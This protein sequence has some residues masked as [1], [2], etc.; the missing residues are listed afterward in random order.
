[1]R[2]TWQ[3]SQPAADPPPFVFEDGPN[4][5]LLLLCDHASSRMPAE[6]GDL[7]LHA[8]AALGH[9]VWDPGAEGIARAMSDALACPLFTGSYS[10]L[11]V[12]LNRTPDAADLIVSENDG[13][14]VPGNLLLAAHERQRRIACYH[15]PYH[16][17]IALHLDGLS[18]IGIGPL[19][20][21]IHTYTP[22]FGGRQRPWP[23]GIL[24]K[25]H[26]P[27]LDDVFDGLHRQG[28]AVG[29]NEPYDG[30]IAL[31]HTLEQHALR[32][33]LR[34]ILFEV[35]QDLVDSSRQQAEWAGRLL[36]AL[37]HAGLP[38]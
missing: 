5:R 18:T 34:S 24:W 16:E 30:R 20:I 13:L 3:M 37:R 29:D 1:M 22:V 17:A 15:Q 23:V 26:D 35:R 14:M 27:W 6:L 36:S 2:Q 31:G 7:G 8:G 21:S 9:V 38:K 33:G 28:L 19:V 12:D 32:R 4:R 25:R 11:V 10:R